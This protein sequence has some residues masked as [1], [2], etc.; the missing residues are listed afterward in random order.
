M[1]AKS[2]VAV[3]VIAP[4]LA[5][6]QQPPTRITDG[7]LT[8]GTGM[9]L[10]TYDADALNTSRCLANCVRE[11]TPLAA[12]SNAKPWADYTAFA[13]PDGTQQ[14]AYKGRPLYLHVRDRTAGDRNG[15]GV[16]NTWR[17]ARP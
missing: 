11:W 6:A 9:T 14:W 16:G 15:D 7:I 12:P 4:C 3:L 5:W 17:I 13:R 10:Y 2:L 1:N 8:D